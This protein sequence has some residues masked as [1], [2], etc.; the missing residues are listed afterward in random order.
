M[1]PSIKSLPL[2]RFRPEGRV[3]SEVSGFFTGHDVRFQSHLRPVTGNS[4]P[5]REATAG[6]SRQEFLAPIWLSLNS[7]IRTL[8]R[9]ATP[10]T[11]S[12]AEASTL[13]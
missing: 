10:L 11:R 12:L 8:S 4:R 2:V 7:E 6:L 3:R 13:K 1:H 5:Q 9:Q